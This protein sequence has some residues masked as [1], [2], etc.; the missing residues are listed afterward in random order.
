MLPGEEVLVRESVNGSDGPSDFRCRLSNR[1]IG[2]DG[3]HQARFS[4]DK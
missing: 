2:D 3:S 1:R 4:G